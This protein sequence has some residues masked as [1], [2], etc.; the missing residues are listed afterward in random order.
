MANNRQI[1]NI[2][3]DKAAEY[4]VQKGHKILKRNYRIRYGEID[5]ISFDQKEKCIVF[6]EVKHRRGKGT[7]S[8]LEAVT[9]AKQKTISFVANYYLMTYSKNTNVNSRFDVIS[10]DNEELV[11]IENAFY[12]IP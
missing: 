12:Y 5:I 7:G 1:G 4:L 10:F 8:G 2:Y 11:H 9:R 3:E 6:T